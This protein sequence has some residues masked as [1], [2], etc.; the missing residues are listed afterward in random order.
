[1]KRI[2]IVFPGQGSQFIGMGKKFHDEFEIVKR[3]YEEANDI[4]GF[5]LTKLC[6][7]G[8]LEELT[9]TEN[10]QPALLVTCFALFK[11]FMKEI[12]VVPCF[13]AGHSLGEITALT[14]SEAIKFSDA[15]KIVRKRG[16]LMSEAVKDGSGAMSAIIGISPDVVNGCCNS[17]SNSEHIAVVSNIN[18]KSQVVISGHIRAVELAGNSLSK[19]GGKVI[20][21]NVSAPFH[22]P[23]MEQAANLFKDELLNY[24]FKDAKWKVISNVTA[25]PYENYDGLIE[26]LRQHIVQPVRW[27]E[28]IEYLRMQNL[29]YI[30]EVGPKNV[31]KDLF[32]ADFPEMS[33]CSF[34]SMEDMIKLKDI[35]ST[36]QKSS[37]LS[38]KEKV[39]FL[40]LCLSGAVCTKNNNWNEDEYFTGV[41]EPYNKIQNMLKKI[42]EEGLRINDEEIFHALELLKTIFETKG[43]DKEE[44][45]IRIKEI[46]NETKV[47]L[48]DDGLKKLYI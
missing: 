38:N 17:H 5:D 48:T 34:N 9:R 41:V 26:N 2:A 30:I 20:K 27:R 12:G 19:M 15:V 45:T 10:A 31:L 3:I 18:S 11:V 43:V 37:L 16:I 8:Q 13:S 6:F 24:N 35:L 4:L 22:S 23:L 25:Q 44:Q 1:M 42:E 7:S 39:Y 32:K 28:T 29:D 40:S 33:V 46:L 47:N 21:L 36:D 14:C